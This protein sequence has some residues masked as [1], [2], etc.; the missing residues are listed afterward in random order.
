M[1][2]LDRR[3]FLGVASVSATLPSF[4][5]RTGYAMTDAT[6]ALPGL[7]DNRILV[8]VQLAGGN[9]GLNTL[10][11]F[12]D[13]EYHKARPKLAL[14][15]AKLLKLNDSVALHGEMTDMK[16]LYDDARLAI[17]QNVGYPNPNRS[18]FRATEIWETASASEKVLQTGWMGRYFDSECHKVTSPMLGLQVG[19]RPAQTFAHPK[20]RAVTLANPDLFVWPEKG[21]LA[22]G[23]DR[24]N[25]VQ[26][27]DNPTLDFLQR[28]SNTTL[29]LAKRIQ[30]ALKDSKTTKD[31]L[32][33]SF[34]Q[35]LKLVAQMIAAEIPTRVYYV[36]LGGFDTHANQLGR[37]A[38]LLQELSQGL[39]TFCRDLAELGHLDRTLVMTFSEFGRRVEENRSLGTD[40]GTANVMFLA[41]GKVK[42]G[43]Y[44]KET[45]LKDLDS[46]DL[47]HTTDFR[48][49]YADVLKN[50]L[51]ADPVK[52][53]GEK[54]APLGLLG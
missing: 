47:K 42:G 26:K 46:G 31:Y 21:P 37:H 8:I 38:G 27:T 3:K 17:V 35:S 36:S 44:G 7:S 6:K 40:H 30:A 53:L 19:E 45:K 22:S 11:P 20:S 23:M 24:L 9:D 43:L 41:G 14:P 25:Q 5:A 39:G 48:S 54:F 52:V 32:H 4:V 33:F 18:H 29:S 49:I 15:I 50:W 34:S 16:K 13:A 10:V 51:N 1:L 28:E 12:N 2:S